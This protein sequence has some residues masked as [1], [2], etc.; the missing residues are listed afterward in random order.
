MKNTRLETRHLSPDVQEIVDTIINGV[1]ALAS[2][3]NSYTD[4]NSVGGTNSQSQICRFYL[5]AQHF[6][7]EEAPP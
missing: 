3:G 1:I 7:G 5:I 4:S 6:S 2:K